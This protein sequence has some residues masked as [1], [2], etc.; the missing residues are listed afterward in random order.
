M[1]VIA[2]MLICR[3]DFAEELKRLRSMILPEYAKDIYV[4]RGVQLPP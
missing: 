1:F 3:Y 2:I 4:G